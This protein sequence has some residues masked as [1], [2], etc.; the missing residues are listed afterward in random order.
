VRVEGAGRLVREQERP[1]ADERSG[2]ATLLFSAGERVGEGV[3]EGGEADELE[4]RDRLDL[5]SAP[6]ARRARG[7]ATF[8]RR[9]GLPAG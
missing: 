2:E 9:S 3:G 7:G 5:A 1:P 8:S 4:R 6:T